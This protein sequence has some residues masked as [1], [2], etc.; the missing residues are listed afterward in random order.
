[1]VCNPGPDCP[2]KSVTIESPAYRSWVVKFD[3]VR[4]QKFGSS[5]LSE[6]DPDGPFHPWPPATDS[7]SRATTSTQGSPPEILMQGQRLREKSTLEFGATCSYELEQQRNAY[8]GN[9]IRT[10]PDSSQ[11]AALQALDRKSVV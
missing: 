1:M 8:S 7:T 5:D 6:V 9:L 3:V 2:Y 4:A 10:T 11:A